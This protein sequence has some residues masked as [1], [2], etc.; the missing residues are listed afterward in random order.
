M[1]TGRVISSRDIKESNIYVHL[2][3]WINAM[4]ELFIAIQPANK[5]SINQRHHEWKEKRRCKM[6]FIKS[7]HDKLSL[8]LLLPCTISLSSCLFLIRCRARCRN[9]LKRNPYKKV[10]SIS[11]MSSS[12]QKFFIH[13]NRLHN[14]F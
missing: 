4:A 9:I 11:D 8:L 1:S 5:T 12:C 2:G 13:V 7:F 6:I 14:E 3:E 10:R